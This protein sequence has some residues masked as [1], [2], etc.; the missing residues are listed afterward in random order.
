MIELCLTIDAESSK[1]LRGEQ[2]VHTNFEGDIWTQCITLD[3]LAR[4][5]GAEL[6]FFYPL[7]ELAASDP[8]AD[9]LAARLAVTHELGV[10]LHRP[11]AAFPGEQTA[12]LLSAERQRLEAIGGRIMSVRAG[13]YNTGDQAAWI[14]A[15]KQAG[16][17]VDSSVWPGASTERSWESARGAETDARLWGGGGV[18]YDYRGAPVAGAYRTAADSLNVPGT[19]GVIEAPIGAVVYEEREV[20]PFLLDVHGMTLEVLIRGIEHL[21]SIAEGTAFVVLILHS[22]GLTNG[23]QLTHLGRRVEGL[24]RWAAAEGIPV[25]ALGGLADE[26]LAEYGPIWALG[27]HARWTAVDRS[28]LATLVARC[29]RC[30]SPLHDFHCTACGW[31]GTRLS[32]TLIDARTEATQPPV[33]HAV[34]SRGGR[35]FRAALTLFGGGLS[36]GAGNTLAVAARVKRA[37]SRR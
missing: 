8:R 5:H 4:T 3:R 25:R 29:P 14:N 9:E 35:Y 17:E 2:V 32:P 20:R 1:E 18:A 23:D 28:G 33:V 16:L 37:L 13:G 27:Q 7:S 11:F 19:G 15:L 26:P 10:H 34:P 21:G 6:T 30:K 31:V 12:E 22:Y 24:L 36:V